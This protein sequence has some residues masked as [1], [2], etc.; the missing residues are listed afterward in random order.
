M[1]LSSPFCLRDEQGR[2]HENIWQASKLYPYVPAITQTYSRW[3]P[4][5]IWQHETEIHVQAQDGALVP[6]PA[7]WAWRQKLLA[8]P[9][10]VRYPVGYHHRHTCLC[11]FRELPE[12]SIDPTPLDYVTARKLIYVPEYIRLV[13]SHPLFVSLQQRFRHGENLLILDVDGPHEESLPYYR[14]KYGVPADF[15][16]RGSVLASPENLTLLLHDTKHP[17]GHGYAL[18]EALR[19]A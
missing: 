8:N 5:I 17:Y 16:V 10:P 7:Y 18:C 3:D 2:F 12:G 9:Y 11:S 4:R 14:H 1:A 15:I 19:M 6:L 13:R